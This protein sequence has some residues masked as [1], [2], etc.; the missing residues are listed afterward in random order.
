[1]NREA[2]CSVDVLSDQ[3]FASST[4]PASHHAKGLPQEDDEDQSIDQG[5]QAA[6]HGN[7]RRNRRWAEPSHSS[8]LFLDERML[9]GRTLVASSH[10]IVGNGSVFL[11]I[12]CLRSR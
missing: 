6:E 5:K 4:E 11:G 8:S 9:I 3:R 7:H 1:M 12:Q 2:S 10:E